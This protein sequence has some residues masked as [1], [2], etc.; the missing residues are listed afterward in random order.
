MK[1]VISFILCL[2]LF[3]GLCPI[4]AYAEDSIQMKYIKVLSGEGT[5]TYPCLW[6]SEEVF[7]SP[8]A[9]AEMTDFVAN[10][11]DGSYDVEFYRNYEGM[12]ENLY[13]EEFLKVVVTVNENENSADVEVMN[14]SYTVDCYI[15]DETLY[16]P[17]EK[18]LYL[19][20]ADWELMDDSLF[21]TPLSYT[22]LDFWAIHQGDL[23]RIK[24]KQ[25]DTLIETGW[26]WNDNII[27]QSV[28][29]SLS[30]VFSDFDGKIF[31][32]TWTEE[33][34]IDHLVTQEYYK[35]AILQLAR[36][37]IE[38]VSEDVQKDALK[39]FV[40]STFS[41]SSGSINEMKDILAIGSNISDVI[42]STEDAVEVLEQIQER[43][44]FIKVSD[45]LKNVAEKIEN[46]EIDTSFLHIPELDSKVK[47]LSA[48]GDALSILQCVWNAYDLADTVSGLDEEYIEEIKILQDYEY[49]DDLNEN[50]IDYVKSSAR[51]LIEAHENPT[52]AG[53]TAGIENALALLLSTT[54]QES[55]Q[56]K[57]LSVIGAVG[58]CC[59]IVNVDFQETYDTYAELGLVTFSIKVEQLVQRLLQYN[60][61]RYVEKE[62]TTE[63]LAEVRNQLML[64]LKLNLRN[65]SNLYDLNVK[66]NQNENWSSTDEAK[67]LYNEIVLAYTMLV[68][69]TNTKYYDSDIILKDN[70]DDIDF[71][72]P[73]AIQGILFD[74]NDLVSYDTIIEEYKKACS[75]DS[76]DWLNNPN[77]YEEMYPHTSP[78]IMYNYHTPSHYDELLNADEPYQLA[79]MYYDIDQNG[80]SELIIVELHHEAYPCAIFSY[81]GS[82]AVE[83]TPF[84][85]DE[86]IRYSIFTDGT[87]F[88]YTD[89]SHYFQFN[90]DGY[91]LKEISLSQEQ[92]EALLDIQLL[93]TM[94]DCTIF[95]E[96]VPASVRTE[97]QEVSSVNSGYTDEEILSM[98]QT[99][100]RNI[101]GD[102]I[103][104][105][106]IES[107][108]ES[109]IIIQV[110][111]DMDDHWLTY[112]RYYINRYTATG[113]NFI[114]DTID[115]K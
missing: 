62:L 15:R 41:V 65:K 88:V 89:G 77:K 14:Q 83:V 32:G 98:A 95:A 25:E 79:Y 48:V 42:D 113:T 61:L 111:E 3:L 109:E 51:I 99:Y 86:V 19:L 85:S 54:F 108:S 47:E 16:L 71:S 66:G 10:S 21:V 103:P 69:L 2:C 39:S 75:I 26:Y 8:D 82:E 76:D 52:S 84:A 22:I 37:D 63:Q 43:F 60:P 107:S 35:D 78:A 13:Y 55:P 112:D 18:L 93:F 40:N 46:G 44:P 12:E 58:N 9:L 94:D 67:A 87:I 5:K 110:Y 11:M 38:Y 100:V 20:H 33:G 105:L 96:D 101:Y 49:R 23:A 27:L 24:S 34:G 59:G 90:D 91:T 115:L 73:S 53:I 7:C 29:S 56:G 81:N 70:I 92:V 36:D 50:V 97:E 45:K 64:Y 30:G 68:E 106:K 4:P 17:L 74:E 102:N 28:Y 57:A 72:K 1:K 6:D 31:L 114:G 80:I 104:N